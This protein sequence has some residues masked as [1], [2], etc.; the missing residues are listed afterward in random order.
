MLHK[1]PFQFIY[2]EKDGCH[3]LID[4]NINNIPAKFIIDTG[5][6]NTVM[7]I[8]GIG[9]FVSEPEPELNEMKST[10]VGTD[11]LTSH[12][13]TIELLSMA[14][15][16][17]PQYR[18]VLLDLSHVNNVF[19]QLNLEPIDGILGGDLFLKYKAKIDYKYKT[20]TFRTRN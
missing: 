20:L 15:F 14:T 4:V 16:S 17:K 7:D 9:K 1:I 5:A 19:Q 18:V 11:S 3:I 12:I 10:G 2:A 8:G 13:L 6:S